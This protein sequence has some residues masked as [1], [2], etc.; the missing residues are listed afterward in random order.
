MIKK[1]IPIILL[2]QIIVF[3]LTQANDGVYSEQDESLSGEEK[4][5]AVVH[6]GRLL[7]GVRRLKK[8]DGNKEKKE[9]KT[10]PPKETDA[11]TKSPKEIDSPTKAPN[12]PTSSTKAPT[13]PPKN[14][15]GKKKEKGGKRTIFN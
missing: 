4:L 12:P 8:D 2:L 1:S 13:K 3:A 6:N 15:G 7:T 9:K 11:P 5:A 14:G 10:K